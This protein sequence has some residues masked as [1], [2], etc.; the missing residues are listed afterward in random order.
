MKYCTGKTE[1]KKAEWSYAD[2]KWRSYIDW[3]PDV[4]TL[5]LPHNWSAT[6]AKV[7]DTIGLKE[8]IDDDRERMDQDFQLAMTF[9][10]KNEQLFPYTDQ[11]IRE[12]FCKATHVGI[13]L[14]HSPKRRFPSGRCIIGL[15]CP[16][17]SLNSSLES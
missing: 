12:K 10:K 11:E 17:G 14:K 5:T 2:S 16:I 15:H 7:I 8:H 13:I 4:G 3:L 9:I 1:P 6:Y